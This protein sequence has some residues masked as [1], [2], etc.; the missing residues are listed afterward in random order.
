MCAKRVG[1]SFAFT[2]SCIGNKVRKASQKITNFSNILTMMQF[3]LEMGQELRF[4]EHK[5]DYSFE[6][7]WVPQMQYLKRAWISEREDGTAWG[8][9][10]R[11]MGKCG[12]HQDAQEILPP[13]QPCCCARDAVARPERVI[14]ASGRELRNKAASRFQIAASSSSCVVLDIQ[15]PPGCGQFYFRF[16][17]DVGAQATW[18]WATVQLW[19]PRSPKIKGRW[20]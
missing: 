8:I 13:S 12:L 14:C 9:S 20:V 1:V 5:E 19:W 3:C 2:D 6:F 10:C 4:S 17:G 11:P 15:P 7:W 16:Y 18:L